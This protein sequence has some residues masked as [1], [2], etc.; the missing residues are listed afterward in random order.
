MAEKKNKETQL[1]NKNETKIYIGPSI[2]KYGLS[3]G[4]I[5]KGELPE[6][7]KEAIKE[8]KEIEIL[9][10]P[11]DTNLALKKRNLK[12]PGTK[13]NIIYKALLKKIGGK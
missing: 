5:Y 9:F 8:Y 13:E 11:V 12:T 3:S 4:A 1:K 7:V 6:N 10:I 2:K